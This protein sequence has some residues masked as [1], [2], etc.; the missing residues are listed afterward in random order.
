MIC[1]VLSIHM[2]KLIENA[3]SGVKKSVAAGGYLFLN[4]PIEVESGCRLT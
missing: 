3:G 4:V 1:S 2:G